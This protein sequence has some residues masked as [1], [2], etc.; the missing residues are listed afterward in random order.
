MALRYLIERFS[1]PKTG[2]V[3]GTV[4]IEQAFNLLK[5]WQVIGYIFGQFFVK[6]AQLGSGSSVAICT[7]YARN[8]KR[9]LPEPR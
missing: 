2:A 4:E 9:I 5:K 6:I 8:T 3:S 1:S 7:G